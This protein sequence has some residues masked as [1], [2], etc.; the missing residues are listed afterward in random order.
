LGGRAARSALSIGDL[1]LEERRIRLTPPPADVLG[2]G[3]YRFL[4]HPTDHSV[5]PTAATCTLTG[6]Q[7][8]PFAETAAPS[9]TAHSLLVC[10]GP[11]TL[12]AEP[13]DDPAKPQGVSLPLV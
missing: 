7:V 4:E 12:E 2:L 9:L 8:R 1:P 10:D 13:N 11:V 6:F 5:L 3:A